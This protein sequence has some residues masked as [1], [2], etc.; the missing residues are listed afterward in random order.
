MARE[1]A[2]ANNWSMVLTT[3]SSEDARGFFAPLEDRAGVK[4]EAVVMGF[5]QARGAFVVQFAAHLANSRRGA[6]HG[7][8]RG[9][10]LKQISAPG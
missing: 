5:L 10:A 4:H 9:A 6:A 8:A 7:K 2:S 1:S 3:A